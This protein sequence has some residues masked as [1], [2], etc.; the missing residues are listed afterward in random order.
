VICDDVQIPVVTMVVVTAATWCF[1]RFEAMHHHDRDQPAAA[2]RAGTVVIG[3]TGAFLRR[4]FDVVTIYRPCCGHEL[5]ADVVL[6]ECRHA[7]SLGESR[8][9]ILY[10][11]Q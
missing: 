3:A 2:Q 8:Q 9:R 10:S 7:W 5:T 6:A 4:S 1:V 11:A